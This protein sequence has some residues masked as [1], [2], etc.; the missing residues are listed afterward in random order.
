MP[1]VL[2]QPS[3]PLSSYGDCAY[4]SRLCHVG[5]FMVTR[6]L[7][8]PGSPEDYGTILLLI[9]SWGPSLRM[10]ADSQASEYASHFSQGCIACQMELSCAGFK[11]MLLVMGCTAPSKHGSCWFLM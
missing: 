6:I 4:C 8:M 10:A 1:A 9:G 7:A 3:L 11:V 2:R 5:L